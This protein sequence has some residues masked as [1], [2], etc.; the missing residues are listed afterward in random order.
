MRVIIISSDA[1]AHAPKGGILFDTLRTNADN[2]GMFARYG[3]S[4]LAMILWVRYGATKYS[5]FT[6]ASIHPGV[7]RT[8]L[9]SGA[10]GSPWIVRTIGKAASCVFTAVE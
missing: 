4:K 1:Y 2:L 10:T 5:Q 7:V 6:L 9:L 8:N 3:Q